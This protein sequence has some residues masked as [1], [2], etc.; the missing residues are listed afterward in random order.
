M[1]SDVHVDCG[2]PRCAT[3]P[4]GSNNTVS[5][6]SG[7]W[8]SSTITLMNCKQKEE[9]PVLAER[10]SEVTVTLPSDREI[11]F[12][13]YFDRRCEILFE[14]WT[15]PAHLRRWWGCEG[16]T[17]RHC[18]I[19]LRV[20]GGWNILMR[21]SDGSEHPFQGAYREVA[22]PNRLVYTECYVMPHIGN[23]EW[24]TTVA[25]EP[26]ETGTLVTHT[27]LHKSR[28]ARDGHLQAGMQAG[29][30]QTL[31]RLNEYSANL[32]SLHHSHS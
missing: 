24:L 21:M 18:E 12:V 30:V 29:I 27:I 1:H 32:P 9:K 25:F 17:I 15:V 20:G 7:V 10:N 22:R 23:P 26:T 5:V 19:D 2:A 28:Q 13:R 8:I 31:Q 14:A 3:W 11:A 6:G 16:S 4:S